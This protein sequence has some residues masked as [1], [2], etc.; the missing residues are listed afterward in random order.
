MLILNLVSF[1]VT[2]TSIF[3][4]DVCRMAPIFFKQIVQ[5]F[6]KVVVED[7]LVIVGCGVVYEPSEESLEHG[8]SDETIRGS[9]VEYLHSAVQEKYES[10][11][12]QL[13]SECTIPNFKR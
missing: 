13:L 1:L 10:S 2:S 4:D 8:C 7:V 9:P 11:V 3:F 6:F 12:K 5:G